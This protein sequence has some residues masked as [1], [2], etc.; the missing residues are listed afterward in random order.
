MCVARPKEDCVVEVGVETH[1][2]LY[3][4]PFALAENRVVVERAQGR[5]PED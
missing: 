5:L 3:A 4:N 2:A 1:T